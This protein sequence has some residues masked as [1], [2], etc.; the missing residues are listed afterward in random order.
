MLQFDPSQ[1]FSGGFTVSSDAAGAGT[2]IKFLPNNALTGTPANSAPVTDY[3]TRAYPYDCICYITTVA[4]GKSQVGTGFIIGPN[5]I[6][7]AAHV[8]AGVLIAGSFSPTAIMVYPG[9]QT[10]NQG[11]SVT[12][13][14]VID[15]AEPTGNY[16]NYAANDFAVINVDSNLQEL[17][18]ISQFSL[19]TTAYSGGTVNITGYPDPPNYPPGQV[20]QFNDIGTVTADVTPGILDENPNLTYHGNSGGPLWTYIGSSATAVGIVS[21]GSDTNGVSYDVQ[22]TPQDVATIKGWESLTCRNRGKH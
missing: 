5:T 9:D 13:T 20:V 19:P 17:F 12:G 10:G 3:S 7:T 15:S 16:P 21:G 22:I 1:S 2:N 6:L 4:N 14:Y 18:G 11:A 8:V